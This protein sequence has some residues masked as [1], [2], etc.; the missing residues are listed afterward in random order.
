[1][2]PLLVCA[3]AV[4]LLTRTSAADADP[5]KFGGER[6][7]IPPLSLIGSLPTRAKP[8]AFSSALPT[9]SDEMGSPKLAPKLLPR[10]IPDLGKSLPRH[11]RP[12]QVSRRSG[13]P[14]VKPNE[15]VDYALTIVRPDPEIDFKLVVKEP[16]YPAKTH[17]E[18]AK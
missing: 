2:N 6:T 3:A 1:M 13:M 7:G 16:R 17:P 8:P 12:P 18:P 4:I 9:F 14:I 11:P 5:L 10:T 15:A